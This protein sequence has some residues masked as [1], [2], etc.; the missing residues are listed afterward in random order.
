M[1]FVTFGL[2]NFNPIHLGF[3][4]FELEA[5]HQKLCLLKVTNTYKKCLLT[6]Y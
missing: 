2:A 1:G 3:P 5:L 4:P 6:I